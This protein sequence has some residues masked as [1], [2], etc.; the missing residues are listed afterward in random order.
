[1]SAPGQTSQSIT[2]ALDRIREAIETVP[3]TL[4]QKYLQSRADLNTADHECLLSRNQLAVNKDLVRAYFKMIDSG[5]CDMLDDF[6]D[7]DYVDHNPQFPGLPHGLNGLRRGFEISLLAWKDF[8]HEIQDQIAEGDRVM[9]RLSCRGTHIG[10]F[11]GF[12]PTGA[13]IKM[14]GITVHRISNGKLAE[15]WAQIDVESVLKQLRSN[16]EHV[17]IEAASTMSKGLAAHSELSFCQVQIVDQ[18]KESEIDQDD[19]EPFNDLRVIE[20]IGPKIET[21]LQKAGIE[22]LVSLALT[23]VERLKEILMQSDNRLG[24]HDPTSWPQQAQLAAEKKWEELESLKTRLKGDR[25][26]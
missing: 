8:V 10:T 18:T 21:I 12:A 20:G 13:V 2:E 16:A 4:V 7:I 24:M 1:M 3:L 5:D 15:H 22:N 17:V 26:S 6:I 19:D 25:V 11:L 9:T 23:P 14:S